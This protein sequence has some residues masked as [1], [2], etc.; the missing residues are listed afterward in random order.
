[1][2]G[3]G[4]PAVDAWNWTVALSTP[5][6]AIGAR[7]EQLAGGHAGDKAKM[8]IAKLENSR[9]DWSKIHHCDSCTGGGMWRV[10]WYPG[11]S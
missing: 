1:M 6:R 8:G 3:P 5:W 10:T 4:P 7:A 2:S 9:N 11:G